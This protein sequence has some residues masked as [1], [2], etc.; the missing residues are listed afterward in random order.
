MNRRQKGI[1]ICPYLEKMK[2][3]EEECKGC[4]ISHHECHGSCLIP[5]N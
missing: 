4:P 3:T 1:L 2:R 5:Y